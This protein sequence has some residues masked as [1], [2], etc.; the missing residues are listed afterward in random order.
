MYAF[1]PTDGPMNVRFPNQRAATPAGRSDPP[2]VEAD[3]E[4]DH[5]LWYERQ[6]A[7]LRAGEFASLDIP[8]LIDELESMARRDGIELT[9]RLAVVLTHL[10]K[11]QMQPEAISS[12]WMGTIDEQRDRVNR[13]LGLSPSLRRRLDEFAEKEFRRAVKKAS[14]ETRI[15]P[16]RFPST[17]PFT[18]EQLLDEDYFPSPIPDHLAVR[19]D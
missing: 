12:G 8:N 13:L 18:V 10:L 1:K 9:S 17:N 14:R 7:L 2:A 11:W 4:T 19:H 15:P 6:A 16:D 5:A 3:Y